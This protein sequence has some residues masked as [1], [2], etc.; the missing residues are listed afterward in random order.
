MIGGAVVDLIGAEAV[1]LAGIIECGLI[2]AAFFGDD[3]EDDRLVEG[4]EVLESADQQWQ[5]MAIDGP[6]VAQAEFLE[7]HVREEQVFRAF[8]D[9]VG[10]GAGGLAGDFFDEIRSFRADGGE[11]VVSLEIGEVAGDRADVFIDRPFVVVEDDDEFAGG[12][13]DIIECFE[14]GAA[15]E[16]GVSGDGDNVIVSAGEIA[17]SGHA[18]GGGEG[19][20]GVARAVGIMLGFRAQ[21]ETV[22]AFVGADRVDLIRAPGEHFMDVSL[23]GD[24]KD[25]FVI[26][27][28]EDL[29]E[30]DGQLND[31]QI[32][33]EVAAGF[34]E[35]GDERVP[36]F[37]CKIDQ[38][39]IGEFFD[40]AWGMN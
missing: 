7:E 9:F 8:L 1:E 6:V 4:F 5:V 20:A 30:G 14:G 29:V 24:V 32:G 3:V 38:F 27:R 18:E 28:G 34:G 40:I 33:S 35:R 15:G 39:A 21:E 11:G 17:G 13:R 26:R 16:C 31:A 10:E 12:F 36:D 22:E 23:V 19:R 2:A 25:E 37:R